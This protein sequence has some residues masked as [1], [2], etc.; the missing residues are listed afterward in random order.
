MLIMFLTF[1]L[2]SF[3][4]NGFL[5]IFHAVA[6][7]TSRWMPKTVRRQNREN[8]HTDW[9]TDRHTKNNYCTLAVHARQGL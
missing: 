9:Q 5:S 4:E 2:S 6:A 3:R 1:E 7:D 8:G